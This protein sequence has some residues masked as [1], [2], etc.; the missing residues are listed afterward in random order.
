M[1]LRTHY[2]YSLLRYGLIRSYPSLDRDLAT[3][4]AIIG[5]GI[6][7]AM[8]AYYL[9]KKG[10]SCVVVDRRHVAM[11]ST[12]ASTSL[13]QYEI[14]TPLYRLAGMVGYPA[15][16]RAYQ[17]CL[18]AI[19]DLKKLCTE[20]GNGKI[21]EEK[22]SLQFASFKKD[23]AG[24]RE[25]FALRK[26]LGFPV[27]FLEQQD[28]ERDYHFSAPAALWSGKA[29]AMD[30]YQLTHGLLMQL[31]KKKCGVY[32]HTWIR[33]VREEKKGVQLL[34]GEG[35]RIKARQVV[36]ASGYE[37]GNYLPVKLEELRCTYTFISEPIEEKEYWKDNC[38]I[39]ETADPYHYIRITNDNRIIVG[40]RDTKYMNLLRQLEQLPQKA[41]ALQKD[42]HK[43][44]PQIPLKIDFQW[45]GAF[46]S[47]KDG[48]PYIG[49]FA[50]RPRTWFALGYG[51]NGI[52][53]SLIAAQLISSAIHG[54]KAEDLDLFSFDRS[55]NGTDF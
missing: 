55:S 5:A 1:D 26:K 33:S 11:G 34:T 47:S 19:T 31:D 42:F 13:I 51:G 18:Q 52:T 12:A 16:V 10:I 36:I 22:N 30:A 6:T 39:W 45:A 15:A 8:V 23:I 9:Q 25:E 35:H 49:R 48:L 40:G 7:G 53:F 4:V 3:D 43:L 28:L 54:D 46:A 44:F 41:K 29:G 50:G 17:R 37:S 27:A 38:L 32:D 14:D 20:T 2:P 21:F 24:L